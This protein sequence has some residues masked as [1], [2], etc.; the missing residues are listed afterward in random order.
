MSSSATPTRALAGTP[1]KGA[2]PLGSPAPSAAGVSSSPTTTISTLGSHG[3]TTPVSRKAGSKASTFGVLKT[4]TLQKMNPTR[5]FD[6]AKKR[7]VVLTHEGIHW[8]KREE[9]YDLFGEER[10]AISVQDISKVEPYNEPGAAPATLPLSF[11]VSCKQD[12][13]R[14]IFRAASPEE[15]Q[16]WIRALKAA[17][18]AR[19]LYRR[20]TL[21]GIS[22]TPGHP[23]EHEH[24]LVSVVS[25]KKAGTGEETVLAKAPT[26]HYGQLVDVPY[27]Q[28]LPQAPTDA[29]DMLCILLSNGD[30]AEV[31]VRVLSEKAVGGTLSVWVNSLGGQAASLPLTIEA[32]YPAKDG[33]TQGY[34]SWVDLFLPAGF[35]ILL[36]V[37]TGTELQGVGSAS[38]FLQSLSKDRLALLAFVALALLREGVQ[39][40][41]KGGS[42]GSSSRNAKAMVMKI[43]LDDYVV[44]TGEEED[45]VLPPIP[46]RFIN[47]CFGDMVEAERR[48]RITLAW[49]AEFGTDTIL[50]REHPYFDDVKKSL[51]HFYCGA[52]KDGNPV[53]YERSGQADLVKAK[54]VGIEWLVRRHVKRGGRPSR[55]ACPRFWF[56]P[57]HSTGLQLHP[58]HRVRLQRPAPAGGW[59]VRKLQVPCL[60]HSIAHSP[61]CSPTP[62]SKPHTTQP[63][64][65]PSLTWRESG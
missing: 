4:G 30:S 31:S 59:Y 19:S 12:A 40:L 24:P 27:V 23:H 8:F 18:K 29:G 2:A 51:P 65:S 41:Q 1:R 47:G 54:E 45:V 26:Y 22:F 49:R 62:T 36:A 20:E 35:A 16:S 33:T 34:L 14:R 52:G 60:C 61:F 5:S 37:W 50:E 64:R 15:V 28:P 46:D 13:V 57:F 43:S 9:N 17:I 55:F 3:T 42:G 63:R 21:T 32:S 44:E 6:T 48:W 38:H 53:Y 56:Y 39:H 7:F 11:E 58:R 25:L 10:G